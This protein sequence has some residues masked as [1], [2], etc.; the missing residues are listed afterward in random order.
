MSNQQQ[1]KQEI[2]PFLRTFYGH[3]SGVS[4]SYGRFPY[5]QL[6]AVLKLVNDDS[7]YLKTTINRAEI[8]RFIAIRTMF[9]TKYIL[10]RRKNGEPYWNIC[11]VK[12]HIFND[13]DNDDLFNFITMLKDNKIDVIL[14]KT[15]NEYIPPITEEESKKY[16]DPD[17]NKWDSI[18]DSNNI[19]KVQEFELEWRRELELELG[20]VSS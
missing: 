13:F 7:K 18:T 2:L 1:S 10:L 3:H 14:A 8:D 15:R 12:S 5:E 11:L 4:N 19:L 17:V 16:L 20:N 9:P 6:E